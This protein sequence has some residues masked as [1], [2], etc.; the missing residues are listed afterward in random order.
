MFG[1]VWLE[2]GYQVFYPHAH[3]GLLDLDRLEAVTV[4]ASET[5]FR[6]VACQQA[7]ARN[8]SRQVT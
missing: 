5:G 4:K 6:C 3:G 2:S 1:I 8:T 7:K